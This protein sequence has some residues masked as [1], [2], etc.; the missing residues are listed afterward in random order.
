MNRISESQL[1]TD[2]N[3]C[4]IFSKSERGYIRDLFIESLSNRIALTGTVLDLGSGPCD[5]NIALCQQYPNIDIIAV[6]ASLPMCNIAKD[7]IKDYPITVVCDYFDNINYKA[8]TIISSLTLHHQIDPLEFWKVVKRNTKQEGNIF[9][10]DLIRPNSLEDI[11]IIVNQLAR[12]EDIS[13]IN[14]FKNSLAAAFTLEEIQ[15]QLKD[16]NLN[17]ITEVV[18]K[19]GVIALIYGE[20]T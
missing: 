14:D 18:G 8:D 7:N 17:L 10:M 15:D 2:K 9:I 1:M 19:L 3:Q 16:S 20:N 5:Y 12:E 11:N 13:F 4:E 6:D